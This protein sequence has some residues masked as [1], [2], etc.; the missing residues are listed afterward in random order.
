MSSAARASSVTVY[1]RRASRP[2]PSQGGVVLTPRALHKVSLLLPKSRRAALTA[3]FRDFR[4]EVAAPL[5]GARSAAAVVSVLDALRER[6]T[7]WVNFVTSLFRD[8]DPA[9]L[10]DAVSHGFDR[11]AEDDHLTGGRPSAVERSLRESMALYIASAR[12]LHGVDLDRTEIPQ[13]V[14]QAFTDVVVDVEALLLTASL[15][16]DGEVARGT[17]RGFRALIDVL[18]EASCLRYAHA[19]ELRSYAELAG[20]SVATEFPAAVE[21]EGHSLVFREAIR[22]DVVTHATGVSAH[23]HALDL[24]GYGVDRAHALA[25]LSA[26]V[27]SLWQSLVARDE[28]ELSLDARG[29]RARALR[30]LVERA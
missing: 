10:V 5:A 19:R 3:A 23:L 6:T 30:V 21:D 12:V 27:V 22:V 20:V 8:F 18:H 28:S 7:A 1:S 16:L 29:L 25:S 15:V 17:V 24:V 14:A 13:D 11:F 2:R 4:D 9:V 26:A